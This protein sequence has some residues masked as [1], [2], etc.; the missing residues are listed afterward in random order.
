MQRETEILSADAGKRLDRWFK[1]HYPHLPFGALQKMMR[2]GEIRLDG[3]RVKGNER[4]DT[5]QRVRIPPA[6]QPQEGHRAAPKS[7]VMLVSDAD[8]QAVRNMVIYED[9]ALFVLNKPAGLATQGG[10]GQQRHLDG[11]LAGLQA[12]GGPR[13]RLVHRLDKDTSGALLVA[14]TVQAA[15]VLAKAFQSK[16]SDK[17][18]WALVMGIPEQREGRISM[19]MEKAPGRAGER[20]VRS[21]SGQNSTT[22]YEVIDNAAGRTAWLALK[23]ITG[24]THQ[25]RLH[26]SE[27]GTPI[28]GDGKYGGKEAFLTGAIS[29]KLH[30]HSHSIRFPHPGGGMMHVTAPLSPH[31]AESFEAL[32]FRADDYED[33]FDEAETP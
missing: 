13:P 21:A 32:G 30:L 7:P 5:G 19:K 11:M 28:V 12:D 2:K 14:K 10:T 29:R 6:A 17:R 27:M 15:G 23:P 22:E 20:M 26:C 4:L 3:K 1:D 16:D 33:P 18:Y 9:D 8:R 31:M 24:R 25:L